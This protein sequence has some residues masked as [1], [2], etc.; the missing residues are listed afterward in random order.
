MTRVSGAITMPDEDEQ[1]MN[2]PRSARLYL[3]ALKARL[4]TT[5]LRPASVK[6]VEPFTFREGDPS[7]ASGS[8]S[9][10]AVP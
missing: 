6:L 7:A 9:R 2:R 4:A 3:S 1:Q 5:F 8:S 10:A